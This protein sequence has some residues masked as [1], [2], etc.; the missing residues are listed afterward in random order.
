M[1]S[2]GIST[3][4]ART[5]PRRRAR[6]VPRFFRRTPQTRRSPPPTPTRSRQT[7][8]SP[9]SP[10]RTNERSSVP[11]TRSV[12]RTTTTTKTRTRRRRRAGGWRRTSIRRRVRRFSEGASRGVGASR[13][14]RG[15]P[16]RGG[17]GAIRGAGGVS[18]AASHTLGVR[19]DVRGP[20]AASVELA[21]APPES[22][23]GGDSR[24]GRGARD[25]RAPPRPGAGRETRTGVGSS[26][27][28][29]REGRGR[30][31]AP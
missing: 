2:E 16:R 20:R 6:A 27:T 17:S 29:L 28:S 22:W 15:S 10:R 5:R 12:S 9:K 11:S 1:T 3:F 18:F 13:R 19:G 7:R 31:D 21:A 23:G 26:W 25:A 8:R 24:V 4:A 30:C 14:R